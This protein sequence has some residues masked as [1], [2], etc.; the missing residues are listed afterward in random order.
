M[1]DILPLL[2]YELILRT[3]QF[4]MNSQFDIDGCLHWNCG[5]LT[6]CMIRPTNRMGLSWE[7]FNIVL[8]TVT[9]A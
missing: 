3:V 6:L 7:V 9:T 4:R 1:T 8:D 5:P 2:V